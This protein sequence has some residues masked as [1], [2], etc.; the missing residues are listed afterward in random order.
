MVVKDWGLGGEAGM[1][2]QSVEHCEGSE[3][4]LYDTVTVDARHHTFVKTH[5]KYKTKSEPRCKLWT[6]GDNDGSLSTVA[7]VPL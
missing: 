4:A 1:N 6:L 2:K 3:T 5:R 7:R